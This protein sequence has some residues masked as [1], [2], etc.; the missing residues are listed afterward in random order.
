MDV[1]ASRKWLMIDAKS[2]P[3]SLQV[4]KEG[5]FLLKQIGAEPLKLIMIWGRARTGKSFFMNKL[6]NESGVFQV[7]PSNVPCTFG[8]DV[9]SSF[10]TYQEFS[11]TDLR[12]SKLG[13]VG[14][15]DAEG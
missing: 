6:A 9:S 10:P 12:G 8:V 13:H 3:I 2:S 11:G 7:K 4:Q 1:P 5:S 15:V 14:F